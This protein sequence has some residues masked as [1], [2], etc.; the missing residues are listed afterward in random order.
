L[1]F[2]DGCLVDY[3]ERF[4]V[5]VEDEQGFGVFAEFF[6]DADGNMRVSECSTSCAG[7][8]YSPLALIYS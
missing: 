5:G 6:Q 7:S 8:F 1:G 3:G 4:G 2:A